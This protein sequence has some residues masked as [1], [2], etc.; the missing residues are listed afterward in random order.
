MKA[1]EALIAWT[2]ANWPVAGKTQGQVK[3]GPQISDPHHDWTTSFSFTC[4]AADT[5]RRTWRGD[6]SV[7]QVFIEFNTIVV[8]DGIDPQAAHK[9]FPVIDECAEFI[10]PDMEGAREPE[11]SN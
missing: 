2:P 10:S 9:A 4:G 1:H 7:A 5:A 11:A 8:R 6:R 3:V